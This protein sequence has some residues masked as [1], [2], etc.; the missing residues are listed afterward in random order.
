MIRYKT[1]VEY[2]GGPFVG[3][4]R[5]DTGLGVQQVVEEAIE[6]FSGETVNKMLSHFAMA[7]CYSPR[8]CWHFSHCCH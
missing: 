4:Q 7:C 3:W 1:Q 5:Q 6:A 8:I 2:D